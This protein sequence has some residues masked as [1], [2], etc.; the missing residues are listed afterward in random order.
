MIRSQ[1]PFDHG[2]WLVAYLFLVG[3]ASQF[4][5][6]WGHRKVAL[7]DSRS[8]GGSRALV[9]DLLA[10]NIGT[11]LVPVGVLAS[12]GA[13]VVSGSVVLL[14]TLTRLAL[15]TRTQRSPSTD[16]RRA[17]LHAYRALLL[18]LAGSVVVGTGLAGALPWQ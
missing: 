13:I 17:W 9:A 3:A 11:V 14:A 16:P 15:R 1:Q 18:F 7:L 5:L 6:A 4:G 2:W 10:W 12:R 8:T